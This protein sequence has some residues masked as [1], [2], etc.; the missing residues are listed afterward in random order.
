MGGRG[1]GGLGVE[2]GIWLNVKDAFWGERG[3]WGQGCDLLIVNM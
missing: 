2:G 3:S 1:R